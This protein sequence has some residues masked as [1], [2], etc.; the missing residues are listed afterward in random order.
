MRL[1]FTDH[2]NG[3]IYANTEGVISYGFIFTSLQNH[4]WFSRAFFWYS[5]HRWTYHYQPW[6]GTI[7]YINNFP[8]NWIN[9]FLCSGKGEISIYLWNHWKHLRFY[10]ICRN[11]FACI[12]RLCKYLSRNQKQLVWDRVTV[13]HLLFFKIYKLPIFLCY[14]YS[15]L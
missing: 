2:L 13:P 8:Y 12:N 1:Y 9:H 3:I 11:D 5:F 10:S 4:Y 7:R 6:L 15:I 14:H